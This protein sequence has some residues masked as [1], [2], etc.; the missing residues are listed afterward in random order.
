MTDREYVDVRE[1]HPAYR[2]EECWNCGHTRYVKQRWR[3]CKECF[4]GQ[5]QADEDLRG[6]YETDEGYTDYR[7]L[8]YGDVS[9]S[10]AKRQYQETTEALW[11]SQGRPGE[12]N[13]EVRV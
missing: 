4:M 10:D 1:I 9:L 5:Q 2:R 8:W 11:E 6:E 13:R 3:V 12:R 7:L